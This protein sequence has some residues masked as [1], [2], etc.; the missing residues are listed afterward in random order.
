MIASPY[1]ALLSGGWG[2]RPLC[3]Q[4]VNFKFNI[5]LVP[6]LFPATG[7]VRGGEGS[8]LLFHLYTVCTEKEQFQL[9][10]T[11]VDTMIY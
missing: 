6:R 8:I 10:L 2:G 11:A 5:S 1:G 3:I 7:N 4:S 9:V